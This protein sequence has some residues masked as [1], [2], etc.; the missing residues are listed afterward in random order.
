MAT[1]AAHSRR[2]RRH[3]DVGEFTGRFDRPVGDDGTSDPGGKSLVA[4]LEQDSGEFLFG[5]TVHDIDCRPWFRQVH[6]HIEGGIVTVRKSTLDTVELRR[7][8]TKVE[9]RS[10]ERCNIGG[11]HGVAKVVESTMNCLD[12]VT[13]PAQAG[14][15]CCQ[16]RL[17]PIDTKDVQVRMGFEQHLCM[18]SPAQRGVE[19]HSVGHLS[20]D[21][22]NLGSHDRQ[23][24]KASAL[25]RSWLI[26]LIVVAGIAALHGGFLALAL[27]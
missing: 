9:K 26:H 8:N 10:A 13:K 3:N 24:M 23:V 21:G 1:G 20:K 12:T 18:P 4:I 5:V 17:I 16:R 15:R 22:N 27:R 19:H 25:W 6:A 2:D 7:R 11:L 14:G